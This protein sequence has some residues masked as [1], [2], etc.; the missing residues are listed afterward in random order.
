MTAGLTLRFHRP[1]PLG[2]LRAEAELSEGKDRKA[3]VNGRL[4]G[5]DGQMTVSAEGVFVMPRHLH[6]DG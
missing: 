5:P 2:R 6:V 4:L 3:L 1:T